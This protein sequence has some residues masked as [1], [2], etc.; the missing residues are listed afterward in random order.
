M[1]VSYGK[2]APVMARFFSKIDSI[3]DCWQWGGAKNWSGYGQ[4]WYEGKQRTAHRFIY[5]FLVAD[6]TDDLVLDHLCRNTSCVNPDHLEA[7]TNQ[8]NITRGMACY[9]KLKTVC[10]QGH[11]YS[12]ENTYIRK[13]NYRDC[14]TCNRLRARRRLAC[15]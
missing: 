12:K 2:G 3:D 8:E 11:P 7:V 9:N 14:R 4:F 10:K 1:A 5:Q 15:R 13:G 6:I